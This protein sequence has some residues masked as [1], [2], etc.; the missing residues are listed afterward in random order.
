VGEPEEYVEAAQLAGLDGIIFTCHNPMPDGFGARVRMALEEFD[1]YLRIIDRARHAW[2][3]TM[4]V[5]LG[6]ECDY[7]PG[8]E[9]WLEKQVRSADFHYILGS[10]HPQQKEYRD[11]YWKGDPVLYQRQYFE[12]LA[13]AAE[14]GFFDCLS[15]PD[16]IKNETPSD[17]DPDNLM[18]P[19]C[20]ALDRIAK[21]HTAME[22]NTSGLN[23]TI[24][25]MNPGPPILREMY[26]RSI[27]VVIGADAHKPERVGEDFH[28]ALDM[29]ETCGYQHVH[30]FLERKRHQVSIPEMRSGLRTI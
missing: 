18:D 23:K 25:E 1:T 6:L 7:F 26:Q 4:D 21:C 15:H 17:W 28:Q 9:H 27:P 8:Y 29:L 10:V 12:L 13:E 3:G 22:L 5:R 24:P 11:R 14:T 19:I 2:S 16:I 30:F 20:A